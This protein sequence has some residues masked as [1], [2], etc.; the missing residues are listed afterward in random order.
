MV[1]RNDYLVDFSRSEEGETKLR[2]E[3]YFTSEYTI[4]HTELLNELYP[5]M[6]SSINLRGK[7]SGELVR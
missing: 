2:L 6:L 3:D 1:G 7:P 5:K 4:D